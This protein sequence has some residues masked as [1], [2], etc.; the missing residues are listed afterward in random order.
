MDEPVSNLYSFRFA[1]AGDHVWSFERGRWCEV[2]VTSIRGTERVK[3]KF[4]GK[5]AVRRYTDLR[6]RKPDEG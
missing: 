6:I 3:I 1:R 4:N 2:E 5:S